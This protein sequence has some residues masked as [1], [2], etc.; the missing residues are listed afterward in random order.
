MKRIIFICVLLFLCIGSNAQISKRYNTLS[1]AVYVEFGGSGVLAGLNYD[2]RFSEHSRWGY[3]IGVAHT[4]TKLEE[5]GVCDGGGYT[6]SGFNVPLEINYLVGKKERK[7]KLDLGTGAN[8]GY[9]DKGDEYIFGHFI[10]LNVGYRYQPKQGMTFRVG[11]SPKFDFGGNSSIMDYIW[12]TSVVP[13]LGFGYA[14]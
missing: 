3:R 4:L 9:Y 12:I 7:S 6:L 11:I 14:F 8:L 2:S 10:F 13:Y 5:I 1:R